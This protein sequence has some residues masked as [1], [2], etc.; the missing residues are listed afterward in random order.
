MPSIVIKNIYFIC[1]IIWSHF[2]EIAKGL[3]FLKEYERAK[4]CYF[5]C[6]V[7]KALIVSNFK[8]GILEIKMKLN[9]FNECYVYSTTY[10]Y[11]L[12]SPVYFQHNLDLLSLRT[13]Q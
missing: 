12:K 5:Y 2:R 3:I 1:P 7:T 10:V 11:L 6:L 4:F 8:I 9:Q 13:L